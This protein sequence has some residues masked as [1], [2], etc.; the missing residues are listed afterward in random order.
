MIH[1]WLLRFTCRATK[2][3]SVF[4]FECEAD[5]GAVAAKAHFVRV[6]A[7]VRIEPML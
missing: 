1:P 4:D 2:L 3:D 6:A 5:F 7:K